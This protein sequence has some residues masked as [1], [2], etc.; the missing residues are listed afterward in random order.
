MDKL[1]LLA[2]KLGDLPKTRLYWIER[3]NVAKFSE[4][5]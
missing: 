5:F 3:V 4:E 2:P 1:H